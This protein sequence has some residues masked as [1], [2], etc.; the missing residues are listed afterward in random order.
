MAGK[1]GTSPAKNRTGLKFTKQ[2]PFEYVREKQ[3]TVA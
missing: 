3:Q 1:T 2:L